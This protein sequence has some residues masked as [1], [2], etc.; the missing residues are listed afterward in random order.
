MVTWIIRMK[1]LSMPLRGRQLIEKEKNSPNGEND[2]YFQRSMSFNRC[3]VVLFESL[4]GQIKWTDGTTWHWCWRWRPL[5]NFLQ[6][7]LKNSS[8]VSYNWMHFR[9]VLFVSV[10]P[11]FII[12]PIYFYFLVFLFLIIYDIPFVSLLL[13][14]FFP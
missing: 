4:C 6:I 9:R 10:V 8:I 13:I 5:C 12:I 3:F 1:N 14:I 7:K 2:N 11:P